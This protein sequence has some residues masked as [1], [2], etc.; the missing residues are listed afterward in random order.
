[1]GHLS[2]TFLIVLAVA[3]L[4]PATAVAAGPWS[5]PET[6]DRA[7]G[8]ERIGEA[9]PALDD[10]GRAVIAWTRGTSRRARLVAAVPEPPRKA[11]G[12]PVTVRSQRGRIDSPV[13]G[14]DNAGRAH[15]AFRRLAGDTYRIESRALTRPKRLGPVKVLSF[16]GASAGPPAFTVAG[17][18]LYGAP[19]LWWLR[20]PSE[21]PSIQY[22]DLHSGFEQTLRYTI[23][24]GTADADVTVDQE[25]VFFA[26][27]VARD[28][29]T[30]RRRVYYAR[31]AEGDRSISVSPVSDGVRVPRDV[32][33]ATTGSRGI[34]A[35]TESDGTSE[36]VVTAVNGQTR[37]IAEGEFM[38]G[39][40]LLPSDGRVVA[41]WLGSS[42]GPAYAQRSGRLRLAEIPAS[43]ARPRILTVPVR[44]A[45]FALDS[46]ARGGFTA[47]LLGTGGH[48][49]ALTISRRGTVG[50]ARAL[51]PRGERAVALSLDASPRGAM[52]VWVTRGGRA[53]RMSGHS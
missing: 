26:A 10:E 35:W 33:I 46:D 51:T 48:V 6:I 3:L 13:I 32:Q 50:P 18:S 17:N 37:V 5:A 27:F 12:A 29:A 30:G 45:G 8:G 7:G 41:G 42:R 47:G 25:G 2:R 43:G 49:Y 24:G 36:R 16:S 21:E 31:Q 40:K 14:Y 44:S 39:F 28:P 19:T 11:F 34:V 53:L 9:T 4:A 20:G 15:I 22:A 38:S 52:V 23:P 1:M